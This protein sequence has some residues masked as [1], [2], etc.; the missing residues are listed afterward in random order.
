MDGSLLQEGDI[1]KRPQLAKTLRIIAEEGVDAFYN[2]DLGRR[3]V[4]D[5]QDLQGIIT[6][7]DLSN[8]T[9]KWEKPV[10]SQLSDGH[11]LY[12][13]QL[14]GSGPLLAFIINILDSW[15]PTASLAATW[16]RIV[17]A[18]K[19][20]YGRR[21][22]LGDPDFVDIDQLIKNLTSRDY[23]AGIRKSIFDDRTFQDPGYYGSVLS[24][25]ENH[26]T[27]H[28]SVLAPNGDAVAVTSTVNLL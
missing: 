22:E 14:P 16:Q 5:V 9:V 26:G 17:E 28:I 4:K 11:T 27:A 2:G 6:M 23:A 21:T 7:D 18:F 19:F 12:T 24:Q 1:M 13:V 20:A 8:Y 15:I 3:F 10:T 25:P